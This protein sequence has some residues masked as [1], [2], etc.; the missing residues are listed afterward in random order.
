MESIMNQLQLK[1]FFS[2]QTRDQLL[3]RW[4]KPMMKFVSKKPDAIWDHINAG[5]L[6]ALLAA[7]NQPSKDVIIDICSQLFSSKDFVQDYLN[8][9]TEQE[10]EIINLGTW[11]LKVTQKEL[12]EIFGGRV[13]HLVEWNQQPDLNLLYSRINLKLIDGLRSFK[14]FIRAEQLDHYFFARTPAEYE[15]DIRI[16]VEF[17]EET[18]MFFSS[19]VPKPKGYYF[20]GVDLPKNLIT[21]GFE[22]QI[23]YDLPAFMVYY[24]AKKLSFTKKGAPIVTSLNRMNKILN[25]PQF[26]MQH[27]INLRDMLIAGLF[28]DTFEISAEAES[29]LSILKRLFDYSETKKEKRPFAPFLLNYLNGIRSI[30]TWEFSS[31]VTPEIFNVLRQMPHGEWISVEN[32][33]V[34]LESH[35][36]NLNVLK[37]YSISSLSSSLNQNNFRYGLTEKD[38]WNSIDWPHFIGHIY[39][40]AAFGLMEVAIDIG[41]EWENSYYDD[42]KACKLTR[43]GA[44]VLGQINEYE[45]PELEDEVK[46][47]FEDENLIIRVEGNTGLAELLLRDYTLK[48]SENKFQVNAEIFLKD[49]NTR[50]ALKKKVQSFKNALQKELPPAWINFLN[51]LVK[52]S[53]SI[54]S[55][56][57][58]YVFKIPDEDKQLIR[59][60]AQDAELKKIV[61]K[62]EQFHVLIHKTNMSKFISR[63]KIYGYLINSK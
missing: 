32:L 61:M 18:R 21:F 3:T 63:M 20:K 22:K 7:K 34:Y 8:S 54:R 43:L 9:F 50:D 16:W 52:N 1:E 59:I 44:Y 40:M 15:K 62:A 33:K 38:R 41:K 25:L 30:H 26:P 10:R 45:A 5:E 31:F 23:F 29:S 28:S 42:F 13:W 58:Y 37:Y 48:I 17:P 2:N 57:A 46:I 53:E 4:Y 49:C 47:I 24:S 6:S 11:K 35:F 39:L 19:V 60:I 56:N 12:E 51:D 36:T 27:D 14:E 55:E